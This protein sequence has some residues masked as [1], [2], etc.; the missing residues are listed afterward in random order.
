MQF[1]P[2]LIELVVLLALA[3]AMLPAKG[4]TRSQPVKE[5]VQRTHKSSLQVKPEFSSAGPLLT[6]AE[7]SFFGVLSQVCGAGTYVTA[8]VRLADVIKP[9]AGCADW[10]ASFNSISQ[11]HIDFVVCNPSTMEILCCVELN[12]S[13]HDR[14]DRQRRDEFI[15]MA[16]SSA[17]VPFA[18]FAAKRAYTL[19]EVH[20]GL[21]AVL[22]RAA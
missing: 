13:S 18:Q 21:V 8:K 10:Q 6:P 4:K 19:D 17:G 22:P 2:L 9:L 3:S 15:S 12:D 20:S 16:L 1:L 14:P 5:S 11:K 7:R